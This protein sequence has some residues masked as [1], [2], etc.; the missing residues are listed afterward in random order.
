M[1]ETTRGFGQVVTALRPDPVERETADNPT[2]Q[3]TANH[4]GS[5]VAQCHEWVD[6]IEITLFG[7]EPTKDCGNPPIPP[8][9]EMQLGV[10]QSQ[11]KGLSARLSRIAERIG[12]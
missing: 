5:N 6:R 2:I 3:G 4:I 1:R 9:I 11:T 10:I 12:G 8:G 7:P